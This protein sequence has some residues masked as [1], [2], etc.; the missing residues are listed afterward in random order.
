MCE[1]RNIT[2]LLIPT[3]FTKLCF[4]SHYKIKIIC[5]KVME[6]VAGSENNVNSKFYFTTLSFDHL[7]D[8]LLL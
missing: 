5:I 7:T 2:L 1:N 4:A 3:A 6:N 8:S